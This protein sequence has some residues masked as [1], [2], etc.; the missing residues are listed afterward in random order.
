ME[1]VPV[2]DGLTISPTSTFGNEGD[3]VSLNLNASIIDT[4]GSETVTL[5]IKGLGEY[6]S[7]YNSGTLMS[8][9]YDSFTD[10]YTVS[11]IA[12]GDIDDISFIQSAMTGTID[13]KAYTVETANSAASSSVSSTF[14]IN[15]FDKI[16]TTGDDTLL[17]SGGKALDGFTGTDKVVMR[18]DEGIDFT[19]DPNIRNVEIF[20]LR[21]DTSGTNVLKN[22]SVQDV[23]DMTDSNN[24]LTIY[25][26][27]GDRVSLLYDGHWSTETVN[28]GGIIFDK[29]T[30][31]EHAGLVLKIQQ[32]LLAAT[33]G[34]DTLLYSGK[35]LDGSDGTD[36]VVM[37]FNEG[38]D[39]DS[40]YDI[41]NVE[42]FDLRGVTSG[43]NAL[44]NLSVQD[45][46]DMTDSNKTLTIYGDTNDSVSILNDGNWLTA[47]VNDGGIDFNVYTHTVHTDVVL[48]IQQDLLTS[49]TPPGP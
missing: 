7:F 22:L 41:R 40:T 4:D 3:Y 27:S 2:A 8:S 48:K 43:A 9:T 29:Y 44:A 39:F 47:T 32:D 46:I 35:A 25:G 5:E 6:A 49:L 12:A 18:F 30:H 1:I 20:D 37:R 26:D 36:T 31:S 10:T 45:V 34:D 24:T 42:I 11:G 33:P 38:I 14:D 19:T 15:I 21:G 17:Y 23:I 13:V 28:E 16:A